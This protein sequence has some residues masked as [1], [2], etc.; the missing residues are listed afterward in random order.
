V[1]SN[2]LVR[3]ATLGLAWLHAFP[4]KKH[5]LLFLD[6]PSFDEAWKGF[7]ALA[8]IALYLLP[9]STQARLLTL[10]W[11]RARWLLAAAGWTLA[12]VH[13]VPALDHVPRF[14]VVPS[15]ADAWRGFGACIAAAWLVLPLEVQ[16]RA[17]ASLHA[18]RPS[19]AQRL[20]AS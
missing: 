10:A 12:V 5:V 4:A 17:I 15:W 9:T 7:G 20:R 6:E 3:G 8:A 14:F 19:R 16:A 13:F 1:K 11:R 2:L 18:W